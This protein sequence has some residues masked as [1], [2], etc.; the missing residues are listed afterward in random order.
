MDKPNHI[1]YLDF[2]ATSQGEKDTSLPGMQILIDFTSECA[3]HACNVNFYLSNKN[4]AQQALDMGV[5][6]GMN[7]TLDQLDS[8]LKQK[9]S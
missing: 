6:A 4:A 5:E 3:T 9:K 2:F 8:L 7:S 1:E